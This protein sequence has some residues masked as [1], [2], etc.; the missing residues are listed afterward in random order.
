MADKSNNVPEPRPEDKVPRTGRRWS[1]AEDAAL[2]KYYGTYGSKYL[3][4]ILDRSRG[5]IQGRAEHLG[6]PGVKRPWS[7]RDLVF[8]KHNYRKRTAIEI[9]ER[10][11]RSEESVRAALRIHGWTGPE[12]RP[13]TEEEVAYLKE[14]RD[15]KPDDEIAAELDRT[16]IAIQVKSQRL[17]LVQKP[18][19]IAPEQEEW[20]RENLGWISQEEMSKKLG[21][22]PERIAKIAHEAG[23]R[24]QA[25]RRRWTE[26]E[27]RF[28]RESYNTMTAV[29]IGKRLGR[30][31]E[32]VRWKA[33]TLGLAR[34]TKRFRRPWTDE[35]VSFVEQN[36]D[37]MSI[38]DIAEKLGRSAPAIRVR[39]WQI[40]SGSE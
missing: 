39:I 25:H 9:A 14:N 21:V 38:A 30:S 12:S 11:N 3:E 22:S 4:K 37:S 6:I 40:K 28:V 8:L 1:K 26:A 32:V 29:E 18:V 34:T 19:E 16:I 20:V 2:R 33:R 35:E 15:R 5:G 27:E 10:L 24:P 23:Y 36:C 13:W 17:G 31:A 7:N